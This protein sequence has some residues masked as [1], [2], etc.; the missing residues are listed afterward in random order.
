MN[1]K[2]PPFCTTFEAARRLGMSVHSVQLMVDRGDLEA[3][4]TP[5]GHRRISEDSL[6]RW[7]VERRFTTPIATPGQA[8]REALHR[9]AV[10]EPSRAPRVLVIDDSIHY[11]N[12]I[13]LLIAHRLPGIELHIAADGLAGLAMY[14]RLRPDALIADILVPGL[15]GAML[16]TSLR[17]HDEFAGSELIVMTSLS[18]AE[19]E[20][21]ALALSGVPVVHKPRLVPDLPPLV[22]RSLVARQ[23]AACAL[24]GPGGTLQSLSITTPQC[25]IVP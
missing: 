25:E 18:E 1:L 17:S 24:A 3:W 12:L 13:A 22:E 9:T 6:Q 23:H 15:D 20:P 14:G 16:I 21:Y 2:P 7:L 8:A 10:A 4:K 11:Q 19:R 5:G